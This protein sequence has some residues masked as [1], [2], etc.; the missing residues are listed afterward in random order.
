MDLPGGKT[1]TVEKSAKAKPAKG[2]SARVAG[3]KVTNYRIS[4]DT[5]VNAETIRWQ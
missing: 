1:L 4:H 3:R 2:T 5:L